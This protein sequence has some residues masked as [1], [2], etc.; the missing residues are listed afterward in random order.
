MP[1]NPSP[2]AQPNS[3]S[4][5]SEFNFDKPASDNPRIKRRS[6]KAKASG[7]K[8]ATAAPP[9]A[10]ELEREAPPLSAENVAR[11]AAPV[12]DAKET[13]QV[14][15]EPVT[16]SVPVAPPR[17]TPATSPSP[18]AGVSGTT[19]QR[20]AANSPAVA[21]TNSTAP[22]PATES[23]AAKPATSSATTAPKT[24]SSPTTSASPHGT[25]PATLYYSSYPRKETPS[26]MKTTPAASPAAASTT[27]SPS[28]TRPA[29][30]AAPSAARPATANIDYRA[31]VERQ[32]REQKSVGNILVYFVYGLIA[33]F[34]I[35]G[36]LAIYGSVI[37][38]DKLHDQ[39]ATLSDLDTK[40][41]AKVSALTTQLTTTQDTLAQAQAQ[42][43]RQQ[44]LINKQQEDLNR[45]IAGLTDDANAIKS[46]KQ[47][48]A[49]E[50]ATLRARLRDLE[51]RTTTQKY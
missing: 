15:A 51:Y 19:K 10:R 8:P 14:R 18:V 9:A 28:A 13:S 24:A 4:E 37:I 7:L 48:R 49:Q 36:G 27:P 42:I 45:L 25:R 50:T 6:L 5:P 3:T 22:K 29:T 2:A 16:R 31:N 46:E 32:S 40:Y 41:A 23:A 38:F 1:D 44:D 12:P 33:V 21:P 43:T 17:T 26:S 20:P 47:T 30:T 34:V 11:A 39:S 35:S